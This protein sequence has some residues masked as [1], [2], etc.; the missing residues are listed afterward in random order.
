MNSTD[1]NIQDQ[2]KAT[3]QERLS[4]IE[5][6]L[7]FILEH[8]KSQHHWAIVRGIVSFVLFILLVVLPVIGL[9]QL[10][11]YLAQYDYS[12]ILG[13]FN[14]LSKGLNQLKNVETS[15]A[16]N[17]QEILNKIPGISNR[18]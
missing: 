8:Q 2:S 16:G 1:L 17:V 14:T 6:K 4:V 7:D 15:G 3:T 9:V 18:K 10:Y 5:T 13:Q 11:Q 12:S